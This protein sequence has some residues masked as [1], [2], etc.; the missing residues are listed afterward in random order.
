[1]RLCL[2]AVFI[3][4]LQWD[5]WD[6]VCISAPVESKDSKQLGFQFPKRWWINAELHVDAKSMSCSKC[7]LPWPVFWL[8]SPSVSKKT[9]SSARWTICDLSKKTARSIMKKALQP[10][11]KLPG[12]SLRMRLVW[13]FED[14]TT[15]ERWPDRLQ[16]WS[17]SAS[18]ARSCQWTVWWHRQL[19]WTLFAPS[20]GWW[21]S[22]WAKFGPNV[23]RRLCFW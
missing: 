6:S 17:G 3:H 7:P 15:P 8:F 1:M 5:R 20:D 23:S 4:V 21:T 9:S 18:P 11:L 22:R 19:D 14:P 13:N 12:C 10:Q 2:N 16:L